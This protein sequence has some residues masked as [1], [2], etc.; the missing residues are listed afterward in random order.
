MTKD[1]EHK[2]YWFLPSNV[3]NKVPGI[4][5]FSANKEIRLEL[6][7]GFETK[8]PDILTSKSIEIIQGITHESKKISLFFCDRYGSWNM[9]SPYP[10]TN[11]KCQYLIIGKHLNAISEKGFNRIEADLTGLYEWHPSG[12]IQNE[13]AF[14]DDDKLTKI[15]CTISDSDYWEEIIEI[16]NDFNAKIRGIANYTLSPDHRDANFKQNTLFEICR[17]NSK[18]SFIYFLNKVELFRQF[19]SLASLS[20]SDYLQLTLFDDDDYQLSEKGNK[21]YNRVLLYFVREKGDNHKTKRHE[22][23][24]NH[25]D[26]IDT[27]P[28]II[29]AWY[30]FNKDLA[31]IRKHLIESIRLKKVFTS[32]DFLIIVQALEG[33]HRRFV[34]KN[35]KI[36][37]KERIEGLFGLFLD[38]Q[39]VSN[40]R[41]NIAHVVS[42]RNYYSHFYEKNDN[43]L[44]GVELF[45]LT[46]QLRI[47]LIC[48]V[49]RLIGFDTTLIN[50]LLD[51]KAVSVFD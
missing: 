44:D 29:R 10:I 20:T 7:G 2:G 45:K 35:D 37:L 38:V 36:F 11:Y 17:T 12:I 51:K 1:E 25:K 15:N 31:P 13:I 18:E 48:C 3:E 28:V 27:F 6:I 49:L 40:N 8:M 30:G 32:L 9:S 41:I 33:Y 5:Y 50:N 23:L 39:K 42:S 22:F 4:L 43:V 34:D 14:S 47:L 26:I 46:E 24:F 21:L 16:E 19:L